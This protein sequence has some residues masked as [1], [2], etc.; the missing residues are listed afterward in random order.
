M[1]ESQ[2]ERADLMDVEGLTMR[3]K[4]LHELT[5][6]LSM[7]VAIVKENDDPMLYLERKAYREGLEDAIAGLEVARVTLAHARR[8]LRGDAP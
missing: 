8:R 3:V 2:A 4:R 5:R 7:E 6:G 1:G